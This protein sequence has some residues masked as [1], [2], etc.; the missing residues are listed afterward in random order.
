L[1]R[2]STVSSRRELFEEA[3]EVIEQEY[4]TV[5]LSLRSVS[6]AIATSTRQLQRVFAER[7]TSFRRELQRVRMERAARLLGLGSVPVA[8]VASAVGYRQP[9]QFAK[10]F[11]RHH[12]TPPSAFRRGPRRLAA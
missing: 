5:D 11:R 9:A 7:G 10:A 12:G 8:R 2:Q 4:A 1:V 3:L 6:A